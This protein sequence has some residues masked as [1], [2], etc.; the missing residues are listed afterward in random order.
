MF[1][2]FFISVSKSLSPTILAAKKRFSFF[3]TF[4]EVSETLADIT[5]ENK[6]KPNRIAAVEIL[7]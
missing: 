1:I 7:K 6:S 3:N 2:S 5:D 4:E